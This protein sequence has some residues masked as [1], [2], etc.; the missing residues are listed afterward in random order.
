MDSTDTNSNG[1]T[2]KSTLNTFTT[3]VA[4]LGLWGLSVA[5]VILALLYFN[6]LKI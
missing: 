1:R 6:V 3:A 2:L 5:L 4:L